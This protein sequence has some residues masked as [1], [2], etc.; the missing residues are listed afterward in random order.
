M[1]R[2]IVSFSDA[3]MAANVGGPVQT[4]F[5]T[6]DIEHPELEAL[7]KMPGPNNYV[8]TFLSGCEVLDC[9]V[10]KP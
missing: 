9:E 3:S 2:L 1:I 6:F 7:L 4:K 8:S 10:K 5:K